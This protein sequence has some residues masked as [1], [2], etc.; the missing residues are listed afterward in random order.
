MTESIITNA[1]I[2]TPDSVIHGTVTVRDGL[3]CEI[4]AGQSTAAGALD[5]EGDYLLPGLVEL[6]TDNLER[7]LIP[8]PGVCWPVG[9]ALRAH[10]T[11][12]IGAGITTVF[13]SLSVGDILPDSPRVQHLMDTVAALR[14][15]VDRREL[16]ADHLLHLRCELT[17]EHVVA[18]FDDLSRDPLVGLASLMDHTPGQRQFADL[19][20]HRVYY[21]GKY[22]MDEATLAAFMERQLSAHE[23]FAAPHRAQIVALS[24]DRGIALASHDDETVEH[25]AQAAEE[26]IRIAEFPTTHA[27]AQA[28]REHGMGIL[29]GGPNVVLGGSQSGNISARDLAADDL[30]DIVSSDYVPP[31]MLEAAFILPK[32]VPGIELPQSVAMVSAHP[33]ALVGLDDRGA[34]VA[35]RRADLIRISA[36]GADHSVRAVWRDGERVF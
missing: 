18:R 24:R 35:G 7:H 31:S 33:A 9:A 16:R 20:K 11:A 5:L 15:A 27:A 8:R 6:H 28:A 13:D 23:R 3:L 29:M 10:D 36:E 17:F 1:R 30:L 34:I 32:V 21:R 26:G 19:D 12:V 22:G 14:R 4:A 25:V 2:V